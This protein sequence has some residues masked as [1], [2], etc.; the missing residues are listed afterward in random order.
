MQGRTSVEM[1]WGC[2]KTTQARLA[3]ERER[4]AGGRVM[5]PARAME[6]QPREVLRDAEWY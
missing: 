2:E 4:A 6:K 5:E 3:M 1:V